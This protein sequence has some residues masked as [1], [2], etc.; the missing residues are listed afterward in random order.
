LDRKAHV[1]LNV[2][3]LVGREI[4]QVVD[5]VEGPGH[6]SVKLD[7]TKLSTGVYFYRLQ[8]DDL[9]QTKKFVLIR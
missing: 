8:V 9:S 7:A 5:K 3:D 1:R 6:K 2:Y 4:L